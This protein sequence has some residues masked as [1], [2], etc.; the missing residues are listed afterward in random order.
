MSKHDGGPAFPLHG[1][2]NHTG[3]TLRDWF[4]G[5]ALAGS[6]ANPIT[7]QEAR[8]SERNGD[9]S[10]ARFQKLIAQAC[11]E[12]ADAMLAERDK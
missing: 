2:L 6:V 12:L 10:G 11:F 3:M 8:E 5:Q 9:A 4:A 7:A 1:S